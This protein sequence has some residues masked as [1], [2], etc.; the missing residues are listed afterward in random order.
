MKGIDLE[1]VL[2]NVTCI[3]SVGL[4]ILVEEKG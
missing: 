3:P 4:D 2:Q 1:I